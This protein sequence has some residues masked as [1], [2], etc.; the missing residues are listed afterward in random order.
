MLTQSLRRAIAAVPVSLLIYTSAASAAPANPGDLWVSEILVNPAAVSDTVG[1]WFE[2]YNASQ[3]LIDLDGL[4]ISDDGS[5]SHTL[6]TS[7]QLAPGDYFV[8][9]RNSDI[10][11]NGGYSADYVYSD[12]VLSNSADEIIISREGL[13]IF[14]INY[15][16]SD[17]FDPAGFSMELAIAALPIGATSYQ[18]ADINAVYGAGDHGTPGYGNLSGVSPVPIPAAGWL[19]L[20]S[21]GGTLLAKRQRSGKTTA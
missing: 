19:L 7:Q 8:L 11:T 10:A 14:R 6:S 1:E 17:D 21:L 5:N 2:I 13:E 12:F 18:I 16:A 3:N 4:V 20:S 15:T 9:G